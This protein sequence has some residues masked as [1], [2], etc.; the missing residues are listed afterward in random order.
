MRQQDD[1][2]DL[3]TVPYPGYPWA[4]LFKVRPEFLDEQPG[5]SNERLPPALENL[6]GDLQE[7]FG[8][9]IVQHRMKTVS[10]E[11]LRELQ[12]YASVALRELH[13]RQAESVQWQ[14][15]SLLASL[16]AQTYEP[17][18]AERAP[19]LLAYYFVETDGEDRAIAIQEF[20]QGR[21]NFIEQTFVQ[22]PPG[23]LP[24]SVEDLQHYLDASNAH[25]ASFGGAYVGL[26]VRDAWAAAGGSGD[27]VRIGLVENRWNTQH[28]D[29]NAT[30]MNDGYA[31]CPRVAG[32]PATTINA[33][34]RHALQTL[35]V[36]IAQH[37]AQDCTGIAH[38]TVVHLA[39]SWRCDN[40]NVQDVAD[41]IAALLD[42]GL[43]VGD[44]LL[45]EQQYTWQG[46]HRP[47]ETI[48]DALAAIQL[49]TQLGVTVIEPAGNGSG[50]SNNRQGRNLKLYSPFSAPNPP[51]SGAVIVS[52]SK[53]PLSAGSLERYPTANYGDRVNCFAWGENVTTLTTGDDVTFS[54]SETSAASAIIAG[55][56]AVIQSV[57]AGM[58]G[59]PLS[60][61][62]LRTLMS[63]PAYGED[64][65]ALGIGVMPDVGRIVTALGA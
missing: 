22:A 65:R 46:S 20:L 6:Q 50:P 35:G 45:L 53:A 52:A 25:I 38:G 49:A 17:A 21:E 60:P 29:L 7:M 26:N 43:G 34:I 62:Q 23:P 12:A 59:V 5:G 33:E 51:D 24:N 28:R 36:L 31:S 48:P 61:A 10:P 54:Y 16:F 39:S 8:E 44:I 27:R 3:E 47:V 42:K 15:N 57:V 1:F 18:E 40:S 19:D 4:V 63:D 13:R 64:G 14:S 32:V 55:A 56:A 2:D 41:A 9:V 30:Q 11:K 58:T 37:D